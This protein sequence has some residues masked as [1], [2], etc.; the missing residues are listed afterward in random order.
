[1]K[2]ILAIGALLFL[3]AACAV[4]VDRVSF[5]KKCHVVADVKDP[6]ME[7]MTTS[8]VWFYNNKTGLPATA[9]QCPPKEKKTKK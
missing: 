4:P 5:G 9:E 8:Y 1:M 2:N 7:R 3:T 6:G